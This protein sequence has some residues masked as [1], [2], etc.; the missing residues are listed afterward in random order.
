MSESRSLASREYPTNSQ[1][2]VVHFVEDGGVDRADRGE[3][4]DFALIGAFGGEVGFLDD[5]AGGGVAPEVGFVGGFREVLLVDQLVAAGLHP[6]AR[7]DESDVVAGG[8][9]AFEGE[10]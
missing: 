2:I 4:A 10:V 8:V 3:R 6:L 1:S 7:G 9:G 5:Q